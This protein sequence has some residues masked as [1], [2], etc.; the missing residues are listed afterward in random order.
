MDNQMIR[1]HRGACAQFPEL[2]RLRYFHGQLLSHYDFQAEQNYFRERLK[3]HNRCL[4]GYGTVCGLEVVPAPP[5]ERCDAQTELE[6]ARAAKELAAAQAELDAA[7]KGQYQAAVEPLRSKVEERQRALEQLLGGVGPVGPGMPSPGRPAVPTRVLIECGLALDC[8]GQELVINHP[9]PVDL[10]RELS[11][12]DRERIGNDKVNLYVSICFCAQPIEPVRP[13]LPD[14]CGAVS[15]CVYG[16]ERETVRVRVTLDRPAADGRC[17][18]CCEPCADPCLLLAEITG[19]QRGVPL[20]AA[21]INNGVRRMLTIYEFATITGI[22]WTHGAEYTTDEAKALLSSGI[23]LRFSREVLTETIT[24]GVVDFWVIEGGLGRSG[25]IYHMAGLLE[26]P[27]TP[28]T[29][30]LKYKQNTRETLQEADRV[31][32]IVRTDFILDTCCRPVDGNHVGGRVPLIAD[33]EKWGRPQARTQC[34]MPPTKYG[35][36]TSGNGSPGGTFE[37][38]FFV[39]TPP[40]LLPADQ[41]NPT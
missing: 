7:E 11:A 9:R 17:N 25:N 1:Q 23:E 27:K 35:P 29:T 4:H 41:H 24:P 26:L 15:E 18:A 19:F 38:W 10:W 36:W 30:W 31:L 5:V 8:E 28:T 6:Y 22:S 3:L 33:Y 12:K 39:K 37:S 2:T 14:G 13:L 40:L 16:K 32:I 34:L 21:Q 20:S